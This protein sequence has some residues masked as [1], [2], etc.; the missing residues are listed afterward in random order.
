MRCLIIGMG[1]QGRKRA[2]VAGSDVA[3][4][5][6][7]V[8]PQADYRSVEDVPLV[9]YDA[10]LVCT[11]DR[12]KHG[13]LR[14]LLGNGKHV[15]VEKPLLAASPAEL[16][17]LQALADRSRAVCYT[18]YN[19]RF[20]PHIHSL[21]EVLDAG[22]IGKVHLARFYYGNGTA[23]D[24][25]GS[26]WRDQ[27]LGVIADLGSHLL[28][29]VHFL[30]GPRQGPFRMWACH[31]LENRAPDHCAFGGGASPAIHCEVSLVSWRNT[32]AVDVVGELGSAHVQG[33]CKWGPSI[34][35]VR[36]R[37]FPS[38]RP[39]EESRRLERP[40][41]TWEREYAHFKQLCQTSGGNLANDV[42]INA[43]L[44]QIAAPAEEELAA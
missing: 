12:A 38:G 25:R 14:Y 28:D 24:V 31:R 15:L 30:F 29:L 20:E 6:D 5:V 17:E 27:G 8:F 33:L 22:T 41:P 35:T 32:F 9:S 18:A 37:I 44:Q 39:T 42:W 21:K 13:L 19:H 26:P 3:A 34:L 10:G 43:A 11:P 2:A 1:I 4:T 16:P 40:D 23:R 36:H 7:T